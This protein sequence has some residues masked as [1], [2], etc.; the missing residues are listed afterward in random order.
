MSASRVE[1]DDKRLDGATS[2]NYTQVVTEHMHI[3]LEAGESHLILRFHR[4]FLWPLSSLL[5]SLSFVSLRLRFS[6]A[7]WPRHV[8]LPLPRPK[9]LFHRSRY[10]ASLSSLSLSV[11]FLS[12]PFSIHFWQS[13]CFFENA[14]ICWSLL[15]SLFVS[16][17]LSFSLSPVISQSMVCWI[18]PWRSL[19]VTSSTLLPMAS[20]RAPIF[21]PPLH[22]FLSLFLSLPFLLL[23]CVSFSYSPGRECVEHHPGRGSRWRFGN[24]W[25][26]Q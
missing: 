18:S 19:S 3:Q 14:S 22:W 13:S 25:E 1:E 7:A 2:S 15:S 26:R 10:Q 24:P 16:V 21:S 17:S 6:S 11:L 5:F 4:V 20:V 12:S 8:Y 23:S 9:S